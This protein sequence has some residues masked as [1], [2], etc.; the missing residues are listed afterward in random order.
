[1]FDKITINLQQVSI[2]RPLECTFMKLSLN[3]LRKMSK[4]K[5]IENDE[6]IKSTSFATRIAKNQYAG[7]IIVLSH[8]LKFEIGPSPITKN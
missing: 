6:L 5:K 3:G 1:M 2:N 7:C 8:L 4:S